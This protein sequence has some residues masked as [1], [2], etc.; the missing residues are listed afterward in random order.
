MVTEF[1]DQ[2][3]LRPRG[4][5]FDDPKFEEEYRAYRLIYKRKGVLPEAILMQ[6]LFNQQQRKAKGEKMRAGKQ[7]VEA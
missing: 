7:K 3:Y 4:V 2:E 6:L 5:D 1:M